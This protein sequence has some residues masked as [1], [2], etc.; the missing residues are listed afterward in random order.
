MNLD[1]K[2]CWFAISNPV[3]VQFDQLSVSL[4]SHEGGEPNRAKEE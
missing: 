4:A 1:T 3:A 2:D